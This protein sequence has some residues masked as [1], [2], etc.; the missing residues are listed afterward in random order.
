MIYD[1]LTCVINVPLIIIDERD[2]I[3]IILSIPFDREKKCK[4][5]IFSSARSPPACCCW[6]S[7]HVSTTE[8]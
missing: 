2:G 1:R 7:S 6:S 4:L 5:I 3:I 8:Q